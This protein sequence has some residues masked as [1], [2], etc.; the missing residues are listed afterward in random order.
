MKPR[1]LLHICCAPCGGYVF[2]K[3]SDEFDTAAFFYNPNIQP[4]DEYQ[5]RLVEIKKYCEKEKINLIMG[6]YEA[7]EWF[8]LVKGLENEP[9]GGARCEVC[10]QMRLEKTAELARENGF[11]Y[12]GTTLTISPHKKAE[13]VNQLGREVGAKFN[14]KFYEADWK[15]Q[16]GFKKSCELAR[17]EGFYRQNYCGCVYSKRS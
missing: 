10:Y 13:I 9:E 12:F 6:D 7:R 16:D 4:E 14:I 1:F 15:K 5:K 8:E 3:L 2:K 11:E 17:N